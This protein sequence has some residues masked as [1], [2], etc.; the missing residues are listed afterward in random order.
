V[1]SGRPATG[2]AGHA[3]APDSDVRFVRSHTKAVGFPM[4][5]RWPLASTDELRQPSRPG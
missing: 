3:K 2:V 5:D 4:S 1:T